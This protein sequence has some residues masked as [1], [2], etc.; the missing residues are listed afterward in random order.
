VE[1]DGGV[2]NISFLGDAVNTAARLTALA[3]PGELIISEATRKAAGLETA[4]M[5]SRNL[6]RKGKSQ[7]VDVWI[8]KN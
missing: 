4:G 8:M 3:A 1:A 2:S 6:K 5:E 7:E